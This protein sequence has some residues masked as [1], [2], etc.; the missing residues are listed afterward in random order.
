MATLA[1]LIA[2]KRKKEVEPE[3][4]VAK[5][6]EEVKAPEA[7]PPKL[8]LGFLNKGL[9]KTS[10]QGVVPQGAAVPQQKEE[11]K[12]AVTTAQS[13]SIASNKN[14]EKSLAPETIEK[15]DNSGATEKEKQQ[16]PVAA[17]ENK[18]AAVAV[19]GSA[20]KSV[21]NFNHPGMVDGFTP[22]DQ[23]HLWESMDILRSSIE[24]PEL[25]AGATRNIL[26]VLKENPE[27]CG[28]LK[29]EDYR[30]M[31]KVLRESHGLVVS[32]KQGNRS[33]KASK[34]ADIEAVAALLDFDIE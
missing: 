33:K 10:I 7:A 31:V 11:V 5:A 1:E 13:N 26:I 28:L 9:V 17:P 8:N 27:F 25:V 23:K 12:N 29:P 6:V 20:V 15:I 22:E 21:E 2:A 19:P 18:S 24:H 3:K 14:D 4:V 34:T 32:S 16:L 30:L